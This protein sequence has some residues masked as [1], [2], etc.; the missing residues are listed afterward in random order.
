MNRKNS[1]YKF[2]WMNNSKI[3]RLQNNKVH[4]I[5]IDWI[6]TCFNVFCHKVFPI[7]RGIKLGKNTIRKNIEMHFSHR[8]SLESMLIRL[9]IRSWNMKKFDWIYIE[10]NHT[11]SQIITAP[12]RIKIYNVIILVI[13]R[14]THGAVFLF[15]PGFTGNK[16]PKRC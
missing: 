4:I 11:I 6:W 8:N 12:K 5:M 3:R 1:L 10:S 13:R 7:Q 14:K 16:F 15:T 9:C 2:F